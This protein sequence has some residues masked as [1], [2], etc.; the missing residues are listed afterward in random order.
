MASTFSS[1]SG[2]L[3]FRNSNPSHS[4]PFLE[5]LTLF[6]P[7]QH[8]SPPN[9]SIVVSPAL[10]FTVNLNTSSDDQLPAHHMSSVL[11]FF[12]TLFTNNAPPSPKSTPNSKS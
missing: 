9:T 8:P 6:Y 5:N 7:S 4:P 2:A 10:E 11:D 3:S 1:F 12:Q